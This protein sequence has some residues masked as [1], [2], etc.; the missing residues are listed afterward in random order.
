MFVASFRSMVAI[1]TRNGLFPLFL[2]L[3]SAY[4]AL[5]S[6]IPGGDG[7]VRVRG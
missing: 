2:I 6:V 4:F 1:L 7:L 5:P 3:L